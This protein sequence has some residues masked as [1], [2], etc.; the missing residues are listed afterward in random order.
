M[1]D[2]HSHI[3]PGLDDGPQTMEETIK[4]I[5]TAEQEGIH[6]IV[7]AA[8]HHN[9]DY[10]NPGPY[11]INCVHELHEILRDKGIGVTILAGQ[12][13]RMNGEL[14]NELE[15][16]QAIAI[17]GGRYVLIEF[18]PEEVPNYTKKLFYDMQLRGYIPVIVHPERNQYFQEHPME[19]YQFVKSG[20]VTQITA[21]SLTGRA[22]KKSSS[23]AE[24][25]LNHN[26]VHAV[27]SDAHSVDARPFELGA[28]YEKVEE[29]LD[30]YR[31]QTLKLNAERIAAN[32]NIIID[33]PY[34]IKKR[35]FLGIF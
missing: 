3:L 23:F 17:N 11:I 21:Q 6:T 7:A 30:Q 4:L 1:I 31:V 32:K 19:L 33:Q 29:K 14:I 34:P 25:M 8:H 35:K 20:A 22:D 16:G 2:I 27:A 5:K 15:S 28:A 18:S 10:V 12:E 9:S 13:N 26:L 24:Q